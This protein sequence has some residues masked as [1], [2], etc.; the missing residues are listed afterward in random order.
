M[1][2]VNALINLQRKLHIMNARSVSHG[3][4]QKNTL[5]ITYHEFESRGV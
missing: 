4:V 5:G 2:M 1:A 3:V